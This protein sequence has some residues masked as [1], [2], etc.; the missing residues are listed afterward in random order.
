M[1][2][3]VK[4]RSKL[5]LSETFRQAHEYDRILL[6]PAIERNG[7]VYFCIHGTLYSAPIN[8]DGSVE[9]NRIRKTHDNEIEE[10]LRC[11]W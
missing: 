6:V 3:H 7:K 5:R 1:R 9:L 10:M 8:D 2:I 4:P 11:G